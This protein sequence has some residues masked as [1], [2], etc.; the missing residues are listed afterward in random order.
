MTK[1]FTREYQNKNHSSKITRAHWEKQLKQYRHP[2]SIQ[3][4]SADANK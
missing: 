4:S 2:R 3:A 1:K